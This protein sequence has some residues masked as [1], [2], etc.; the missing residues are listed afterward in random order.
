MG[1]DVE[2]AYLEAIDLQP[3]IIWEKIRKREC[4]VED[5]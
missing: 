3:V 1:L 5:W 4:K 2:V